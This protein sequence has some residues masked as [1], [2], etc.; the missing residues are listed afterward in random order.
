MRALTVLALLAMSFLEVKAQTFTYTYPTAQLFTSG[1][2]AHSDGSITVE[3]ISAQTMQ[4]SHYFDGNLVWVDSF[5]ITNFYTPNSTDDH[6]VYIVQEP[7]GIFFNQWDIATGVR[8][9]VFGK[10]DENGQSTISAFQFD[11]TRSKVLFAQDGP[12]CMRRAI[13]TDTSFLPLW[14]Q[15][16]GG[17]SSSF[18]LP[19]SIS[20][21]TKNG[22]LGISNI[23]DGR[24][25]A[26]GYQTRSFQTQTGVLSQ[27]TIA[28]AIEYSQTGLVLDQFQIGDIKTSIYSESVSLL[29][30]LVGTVSTIDDKL[31]IRPKQGNGQV[32]NIKNLAKPTVMLDGSVIVVG[33]END[34]VSI[35]QLA[36][37]DLRP[38]AK[39]I[40]QVS[41]IQNVWVN[42]IPGQSNFWVVVE[43]SNAG[44]TELLA[45]K[46]DIASAFNLFFANITASVTKIGCGDDG[47]PFLGAQLTLTHTATGAIIPLDLDAN[48]IGS[49]SLLAGT[50]AL[51]WQH[52]HQNYTLCGNNDI[53]IQNGTNDF[54]LLFYDQCAKYYVEPVFDLPCDNLLRTQVTVTGG[55]GGPYLLKWNNGDLGNIADSIPLYAPLAVTITEGQCSDIVQIQ[56]LGSYQSWINKPALACAPD[57]LILQQDSILHLGGSLALLDGT[58]LNGT[59]F[60]P[61]TDTVL[62]IVFTNALGCQDTLTKYIRSTLRNYQI[63]TEYNDCLGDKRLSVHD[64]LGNTYFNNEQF[65]WSNGV[66]GASFGITQDGSYTVTVSNYSCT[67]TLSV[68]VTTLDSFYRYDGTSFPMIEGP[69]T[70]FL[71]K[72]VK[73]YDTGVPLWPPATLLSSGKVIISGSVFSCSDYIP[74]PPSLGL[75][76]Q[77]NAD[78][79]TLLKLSSSLQLTPQPFYKSL[80]KRLVPALSDAILPAKDGNVYVFSHLED[81]TRSLLR[82]NNQGQE[83][84]EKEFGLKGIE[85]IQALVLDKDGVSVWLLISTDNTQFAGVQSLGANDLLLVHFGLDGTQLQTYH[86]GG[87]GTEHLIAI[88]EVVSD[89]LML[90]FSTTSAIVNGQ[91]VTAGKVAISMDMTTGQVIKM[92]R[93][94]DASGT[95]VKY[96]PDGWI[97]NAKNYYYIF[98]QNGSLKE[99]VKGVFPDLIIDNIGYTPERYPITTLTPGTGLNGCCPLILWG[100]RFSRY[101]KNQASPTLTI[102]SDTISCAVNQGLSLPITSMFTSSLIV[103]HLLTNQ[104][105]TLLPSAQQFVVNKEGPYDIIATNQGGC[106][107]VK[108]FQVSS[109]QPIRLNLPDTIRGCEIAEYFFNFPGSSVIWQNGSSDPLFSTDTSRSVQLQVT[110][111]NGDNYTDSI[112]FILASETKII[113]SGV[114]NDICGNYGRIAID[115]IPLIHSFLWSNNEVTDLIEVSSPGLYSVTAT[116][117]FGCVGAATFQVRKTDFTGFKLAGVRLPCYTDSCKL[118]IEKTFNGAPVSNYQIQWDNGSTSDTIVTNLALHHVVLTDSLGCEIGSVI[119]PDL[120]A[121][122]Q[123]EIKL[124]QLANQS[125]LMMDQLGG[126]APYH[127]AWGHDTS[128]Q[129]VIKLTQNGLYTCVV[130]DVNGCQASAQLQAVVVSSSNAILE[131]TLQ[132]WPQPNSGLFYLKV[133]DDLLNADYQITEVSGRSVLAGTIVHQQQEISL[134][135]ALSGVYFMHIRTQNGRSVKQAIIVVAD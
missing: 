3:S 116:D 7:D 113:V 85:D 64:D 67:E 102:P 62:Q 24:F 13:Q 94:L 47:Q 126:V 111:P 78:S 128:T 41:G 42:A 49:E 125:Y 59:Y 122:L 100:I 69:S 40:I 18:N 99:I 68:S 124:V 84:W 54:D 75:L 81:G 135:N 45:L 19:P 11:T 96:T 127:Y 60:A 86:I 92:T 87:L 114:V 132:I 130:T 26:Y 53:V 12:S 91:A 44:Q 90:A 76:L 98:N 10:I 105:D 58:P 36:A 106:S 65:Q 123:A 74:Y 119:N 73:A 20:C 110:L 112:R 31:L 15:V 17:I 80:K 48:G 29:S 121:P 39:R 52:Q 4:L 55:N 2:K 14:S 30:T 101:V 129:S 22:W 9:H 118:W 33:F 108:S 66:Q 23:V 43:T 34:E 82:L 89:T 56:N 117:I 46:F 104:R 93:I 103:H 25:W 70:D 32:L 1:V 50:Y 38:I 6:L 109:C 27:A 107:V 61:A 131:T 88:P 16:S 57:G 77:Q 28:D 134:S 51:T 63:L 97:I 115:T 72:P 21:G 35:T 5:T 37:N 83:I 79:C 120:P 8:R 95:K 133:P 71:V